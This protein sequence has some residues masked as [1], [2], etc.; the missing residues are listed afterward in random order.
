MRKSTAFDA[1][2]EGSY[3]GLAPFAAIVLRLVLGFLFFFAGWSKLTTD[4]WSAAGFL[5][6]ATGPFA[7]WFQSL[8]G[9]G[10]VD[11]LNMWGL[12]LIGLALIFGLLV[13]T[14]SAFGIVLM[15]L[16]YFA[17]F[18]GNTAHGLIDEHVVY[19]VVLFFF[20]VGGVGHVWG[21]DALLERRLDHR[22]TWA[23]LFLG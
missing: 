20:L 2:A 12:T 16:Y 11:F 15:T 1:L 13:R 21:L 17:D 5:Q 23:K 19:A 7:T 18:V 4:A 3:R 8:A 6:N 22:T 14:A 10:V 9:N